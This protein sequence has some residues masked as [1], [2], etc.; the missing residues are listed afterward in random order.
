MPKIIVADKSAGSCTIE[1]N[2]IENENSNLSLKKEMA[3]KSLAALQLICIT[4]TESNEADFNKMIDILQEAI[5]Q[6]DTVFIGQENINS[7]DYFGNY[8]D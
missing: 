7:E 3:I 2:K 4:R 5:N 8:Y 1:Y 6:I